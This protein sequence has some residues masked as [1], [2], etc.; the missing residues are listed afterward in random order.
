MVNIA[1]WPFLNSEN[2]L[3]FNYLLIGGEE[4]EEEIINTT[5]PATTNGIESPL[6]SQ[7]INVTGGEEEIIDSGEADDDDVSGMTISQVGGDN[8]NI[9]DLPNTNNSSILTNE[10]GLSYYFNKIFLLDL[11]NSVLV[12]ESST[13]D[14]LNL[15]LNES[16]GIVDIT[17]MFPQFT[18]MLE[19]TSFISIPNVQSNVVI[20]TPN[21]SSTTLTPIATTASTSIPETTST[22]TKFET[23]TIE[24]IEPT[25]GKAFNICCNNLLL[26]TSVSI[27]IISLL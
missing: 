24:E 18:D 6:T 14:L 2:Y 8:D 1:N 7:I 26:L 9:I 3:L 10:M 21:I 11:L 16:N 12:D 25:E 23:T 19:Y 17:M 4:E 22:L 5:M 13:V 20:P 15:T 27:I